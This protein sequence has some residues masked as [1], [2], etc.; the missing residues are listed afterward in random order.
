MVKKCVVS[1]KRPEVVVFANLFYLSRLRFEWGE[2][3][4]VQI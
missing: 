1:L 3:I 2:N 4:L